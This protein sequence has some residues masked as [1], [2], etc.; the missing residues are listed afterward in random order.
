MSP[1]IVLRGQF[2]SYSF[3]FHLHAQ[4]GKGDYHRSALTHDPAMGPVCRSRPLS[5]P[6][7]SDSR[8]W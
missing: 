3:D 8:R 7:Q 5:P 2:G 1:Q 4:R 6:R